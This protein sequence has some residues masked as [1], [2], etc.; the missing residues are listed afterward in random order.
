MPRTYTEGEHRGGEGNEETC[1][2]EI[3]HKPRQI[4]ILQGFNAE[5]VLCPVQDGCDVSGELGRR[6]LEAVKFQQRVGGRHGGSVEEGTSGWSIDIA[7]IQMHRGR[8][9]VSMRNAHERTESGR[10]A[11]VYNRQGLSL[12]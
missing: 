4:P 11:P 2:V 3:V 1:A 5:F 9:D 10:A 8:L 7:H 12:S 6:R